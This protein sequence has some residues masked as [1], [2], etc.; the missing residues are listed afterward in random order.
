[1]TILNAL[2]TMDV[3]LMTLQIDFPL[4]AFLTTMNSAT[5]RLVVGM[6]SLMSDSENTSNKRDVREMFQ[7]NS[8]IRRLTECLEACN[9]LVRLLP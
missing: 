8:Q 3:V 7:F 1:M 5:E 6:F 2:S 9:A 4:K